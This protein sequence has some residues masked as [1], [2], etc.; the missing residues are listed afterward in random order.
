[1]LYIITGLSQCDADAGKE[2]KV[3]VAP[4]RLTDKLYATGVF[5]AASWIVLCSGYG[6]Q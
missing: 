1:M 2:L 6:C 5:S 4:P 3:V